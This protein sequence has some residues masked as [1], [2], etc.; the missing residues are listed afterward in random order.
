VG[1]SVSLSG[2]LGSI[3]P[4]SV[5]PITVDGIPDDFSI[6]VKSIPKITLGIDPVTL[7]PVTLNPLDATITLMPVDLSVSIKELPERRTH[8]P[9]DFTVGLSLLGIQLLC[10]RLCGEAQMVSENYHPNPCENCGGELTH[11]RPEG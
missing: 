2:S 1:S 10:V 4:V 11:V 8:L 3:G 5:N 6:T 9:A 7:N